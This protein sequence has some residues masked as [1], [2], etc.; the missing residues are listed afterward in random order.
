MQTEYAIKSTHIHAI[1]QLLK[2]YA[3]FQKDVDYVVLNQ[4]VKIVDEKTGRILS[5]RRYS[6]GLH[7]AIEA[8]ENV[9]IEKPS[10]TYA[11]ITPQNQFR[12]YKKL[13][14]MT[15]TAQ[16]EAA[17]FWEVYKLETITIPTNEPI[18][19][20]DYPDRLYKTK[21]E[22]YDAIK[23]EVAK[24]KKQGRPVLVGTSSVEQSEE[25]RK[26]LKLST[27]QILNAKNHLIESQ[28]IKQAGQAGQVTVVTHMAGRGTDIKLSPQ[29]KEAGGLAIVGAERHENR[30]VDLQLRGRAG[31]QGDPGSSQ[32]FVSLEDSLLA[33][34]KHGYIGKQID[35]AFTEKGEVIQDKIVTR[36]IEN[37]QKQLEQNHFSARKRALDYDDVMDVQRRAIY[38]KR[39]QA[40][41]PLQTILCITDAIYGLT[42]SII[43][44]NQQAINPKQIQL[45]IKEKLGIN[46]I[47][48]PKT[49][50]K[51]TPQKHIL[52]IYKQVQQHYLLRKAA[53]QQ[54]LYAHF[55]KANAEETTQIAV[56]FKGDL[57]PID[58]NLRKTLETKGLDA[59]ETIERQIILHILDEQWKNHLQH[60]EELKSAT[61]HAVYEQKDPLLVYKFEALDLFKNL[62]QTINQQI[63]QAI[64]N[65]PQN[66]LENELQNLNLP[67]QLLEEKK[68]NSDQETYETETRK[69]SQIPYQAS[70]TYKR[71]ERVNVQYQD[72]TIKKN[73]KYKTI[74][75]DLIVKKCRIL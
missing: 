59:V 38:K 34:Y 23:I 48:N 55:S 18:I 37:A 31:R 75:A 5:G 29:A 53:Q 72:G 25:V 58:I 43:Q 12:M 26:I 3:L 1:T 52:Q 54:Q 27:R 64:L 70:L 51:T 11:T 20:N 4:R 45:H 13:A 50:H 42:R 62:L 71:N 65:T 36:S 32:F 46:Y 21:E 61:D 41:D 40:L 17:E 39:N 28:I 63:V 7:Q 15:G 8:R 66:I 73:V 24:L 10:Q 74:E 68:M 49:Y 22:K 2:A 9:R 16:T 60:M 6:N 35:K 33:H 69:T 19:R 67:E 14:G 56:Q 30:R 47:I 57:I 44:E